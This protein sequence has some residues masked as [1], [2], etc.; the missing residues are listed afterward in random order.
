MK[1]GEF[2]FTKVFI[3]KAHKEPFLKTNGVLPIYSPSCGID[4]RRHC[5]T[6]SRKFVGFW[7]VGFK[8]HFFSQYLATLKLK[9]GFIF[10]VER[11]TGHFLASSNQDF[12]GYRTV[13]GAGGK[14]SHVP[15]VASASDFPEKQVRDR[16]R[17]VLDQDGDGT[18]TTW[19]EVRP[20]NAIAVIQGK[21]EFVAV[22]DYREFGL[23]WIGVLTVPYDSIMA[24]INAAKYKTLAIGLASV[25]VVKMALTLL[26]QLITRLAK[27]KWVIPNICKAATD[28]IK[29][30]WQCGSKKE[31]QCG[32]DHCSGATAAEMDVPS[33]LR[34]SASLPQSHSDQQVGAPLAEHSQALPVLVTRSIKR[35]SQ[36]LPG[37]LQDSF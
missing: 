8:L 3:W 20:T 29:K 32:S 34:P 31:W 17:W 27:Q 33:L 14:T 5:D 10:Y 1:E 35:V 11:E 18:L 37:Q 22:Y 24:D 4:P 28:V 36:A 19:A 9:N 15:Y 16:V 25:F 23:E 30:E 21:R 13:V 12:E 7:V 6:A 2:T 26:N